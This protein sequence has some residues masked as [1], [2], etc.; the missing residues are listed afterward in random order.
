MSAECVQI[1]SNFLKTLADKRPT[2]LIAG[3]HDALLNSK[4]RLD[5]LSPIVEA[6]NHP[7]LYYLKKSGLYILGDILFNNMSVFDDPSVYIKGSDIPKIYRNNANNV[8]ALFHGPVNNAVTDIGYVMSNRSITVDTF[9]D[10]DIC[11]CGDIHRSQTLY[12]EKEIDESEI[13][14]YLEYGE[15]EIIK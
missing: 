6:L 3:N 12:I 5:S 4:N 8:I 11:L 14:E 10:H 15:W 9:A 2:I 13:T 1:V 7:N